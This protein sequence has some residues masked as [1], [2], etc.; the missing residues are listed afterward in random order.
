MYATVDQLAKHLSLPLPVSAENQERMARALS[1]VSKQ[2]DGMT[3]RT[4]NA[5][6]EQRIITAISSSIV[7]LGYVSTISSVDIDL[8][9]DYIYETNVPASQYFI[10][11][12]T[13][14]YLVLRATALNTFPLTIGSVSITGVFGELTVPIG[15]E[16][17]CLL[18]AARLW[19]RSDAVFGEIRSDNGFMRI[20]D[21]F[22]ADAKRLLRDLGLLK[23]SMI[24]A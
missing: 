19:K 10:E 6:S 8:D 17:A 5:T 14:K 9:G 4:F 23:S 12:T 2:I 7:T 1:A 22:D 3:G 13:K 24:L 20:R 15:V 16:M 21:D 11:G 18:Q